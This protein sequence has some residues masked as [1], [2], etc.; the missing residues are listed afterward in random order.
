[1][2]SKNVSELRA[3]ARG[4]LMGPA[5]PGYVA[6]GQ[7]RQ[8][9]GWVKEAPFEGLKDHPHTRCDEFRAVGAPLVESRWQTVLTEEGRQPLAAAPAVGADDDPVALRRA[10]REAGP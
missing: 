10:D 6:L 7:Y 3:R 8:L 2:S 5:P 1:M 9:Q 4:R